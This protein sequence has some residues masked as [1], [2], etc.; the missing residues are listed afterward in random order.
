VKKAKGEST[1]NPNWLQLDQEHPPK[2]WYCWYCNK[3]T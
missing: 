3:C 2:T 1:T